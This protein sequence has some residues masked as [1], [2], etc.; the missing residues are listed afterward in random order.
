M[1][2]HDSCLSL[3][4][5]VA[6]HDV[7]WFLTGDDTTHTLHFTCEQPVHQSDR[8]FTLVVTWDGQVDVCQRSIVGGEGDHGDVHIG[9][10]FYGLG[11]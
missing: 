3:A 11:G 5:P 10:L 9:R 8:L 4:P 1:H 6:Y 7:P 2:P